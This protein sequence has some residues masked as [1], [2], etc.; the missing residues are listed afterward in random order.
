MTLSDE[1][2]ALLILKGRK[3]KDIQQLLH[4]KTPQVMTNKFAG[5][6][7]KVGELAQVM[8]F[9]GGELV[10]KIDGREIKITKSHFESR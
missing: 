4:L 5:N 2:K 7:W 8:D 3:K 1:I 9:L 10:I 6:A